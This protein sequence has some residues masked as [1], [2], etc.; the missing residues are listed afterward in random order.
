MPE[1]LKKIKIY[2]ELSSYANYYGPNFNN[3]CLESID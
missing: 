1:L 2:I 3:L